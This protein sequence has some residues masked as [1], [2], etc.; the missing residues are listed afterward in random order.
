MSSAEEKLL[1]NPNRLKLSQEKF[2]TFKVFR[3]F[4]ISG[5]KFFTPLAEAPKVWDPSTWP[6]FDGKNFGAKTLEKFAGK[7]FWL[8]P[9]LCAGVGG[10]V[11]FEKFCVEKCNNSLNAIGRRR[12]DNYIWVCVCVCARVGKKFFLQPELGSN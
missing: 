8:L 7:T 12:K 4:R 5:E 9:Q 11:C 10:A 6:P 1:T 2:S 3:F